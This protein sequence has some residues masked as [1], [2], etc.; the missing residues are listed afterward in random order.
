M[1]KLVIECF[2]LDPGWHFGTTSLEVFPLSTQLNPKMMNGSRLQ[3][4][5]LAI[6]S[7]TRVVLSCSGLLHTTFHTE[8]VETS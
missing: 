1:E 4:R 2:S 6:V 3:T 8:Q 5:L 7:V